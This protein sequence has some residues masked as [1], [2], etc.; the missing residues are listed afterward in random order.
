MTPAQSAQPPRGTHRSQL[1]RAAVGYARRSTDKQEQSIPDQQRAIERY[2]Q[3]NGIVLQRW[4]IDDAISGTRASNRPAFQEMVHAA[5]AAGRDFGLVVV[6]DVKRFGRLDNDEAGFYRHT[7]RQHGVEVLYVAEGFAGL[8]EISD[9][10]D[11]LRP[12]KQWQARQESKDLS[13]VTIRGQLTKADSGSWMGG[14]SPHGYDLSYTNDRGEFLFTIRF[15]PDGT[16]QQLDG[17]GAVTR[18]LARGEKISISKRDRGL[19]VLGEPSRVETVRTIFRLYTEERRGLAA[20]SSYLNTHGHLT[21][22]GPEWSHIY[23]GQWRDSTVRSILVNPI[24]AGDMVW[25]R[26]TDARFHRIELAGGHG[27][28]VERRNAH[29]ARLVPNAKEDWVIVRDTHEPIVTR[30]TWE[31]AQSIRER[32]PTSIAQSGQSKRPEGGWSGMRARFLLSG[33]VRCGRCGGKY[34]GVTRTSGKCQP[35][36]TKYKHRYYA[37]GSYIAKGRSA[38]E[39]GA[40]PQEKLEKAV[41]DAVLKFYRK[42]YQ[43]E[44]GMERL[45]A[46]VREHLGHEAQDIAQARQRLESDRERIE[47]TIASLLDNM[48]AETRDIIEGRLGE[49][50]VER[51]QLKIRVAE[52]ERFSLQEAEAQDTV[53][54]V[55][56][57]I[58][59]LDH[60]LAT[61]ANEQRIAALR[62]C[63]E[64][65]EVDAVGISRK[66]TL[67]SLPMQSSG[68]CLEALSV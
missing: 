51:E 53:Q 52:L 27:R 39:F 35:D 5:G 31:L 67:R 4:F 7:L 42:R 16:K 59:G 13:K 25:N 8:G 28:P 47:S 55:G 6:Y 46:A 56:A 33:L 43:G 64:Q 15:M 41:I 11:L 38:C 40:I 58:A 60:V 12:V 10:D 17:S 2:C 44:G 9:T 49:L 54:E 62:R 14:V 48:S 50:R 1:E 68:A 65:L 37:C 24:Y 34:Q 23:A 19:L 57:F 21:P 20:V 36:G 29:G 63:I 22:R 66:L 3:D 32:R 30:R 18:T 45:A 61:H 26:R